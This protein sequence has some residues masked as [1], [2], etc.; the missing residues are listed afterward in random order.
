M[1]PVFEASS[2]IVQNA[3][4]RVHALT[5]IVPGAGSMGAYLMAF[6]LRWSPPLFPKFSKFISMKT[7]QRR[8]RRQDR[9]VP[10]HPLECHR[11]C[12]RRVCVATTWLQTHDFVLVCSGT[13]SPSPLLWA[14]QPMGLSPTSSPIGFTFR[15]PAFGTPPFTDDS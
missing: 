9:A 14:K 3:S 2:L 1:A 4:R 5:M 7:S 8:D 15:C 11:L 12:H 10:R 6:T 13:R